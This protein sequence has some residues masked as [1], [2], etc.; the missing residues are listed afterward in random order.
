[1]DEFITSSSSAVQNAGWWRTQ[2]EVLLFLVLIYRKGRRSTARRISRTRTYTGKGS[3][4]CCDM[5]CIGNTTFSP[6]KAFSLCFDCKKLFFQ[7]LKAWV[8]LKFKID[9]GRN[10]CML[11]YKINIVDNFAVLR[12]SLAR[13]T[14]M[15]L[16]TSE[17]ID[18]KTPRVFP[19]SNGIPRKASCRISVIQV[20][21]K[22]TNLCETDLTSWLGAN[23]NMSV[24]PKTPDILGF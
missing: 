7:Y 18:E 23:S 21:G 5:L 9:N 13:T 3:E 12:P 20:L 6:T 24:E 10:F 16:F 17:Q 15:S 14:E 19:S 1:M 4:C 8:M 2:L 22:S 11:F